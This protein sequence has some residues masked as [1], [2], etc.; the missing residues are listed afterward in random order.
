MSVVLLVL[1]VVAVVVVV[2]CFYFYIIIIVGTPGPRALSF[3]CKGL[4]NID[5]TYQKLSIFDI[6]LLGRFVVA[7]F[8]MQICINGDSTFNN[9][10][11]F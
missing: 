7:H 5:L 3:S 10:Y 6:G 11:K 1:V 9:T 8:L 4:P 2:E